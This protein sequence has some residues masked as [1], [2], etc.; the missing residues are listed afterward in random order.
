VLCFHSVTDDWEHQLAVRPALFERLLSSL[1]KRRFR[2]LGAAELVHGPRRGLHVTF[3]DAYAD[4]AGALDVL[5]RLRIPATVFASTS[6]ADGGR[7]L[8]VPELAAEAATRPARL[9]TMDWGRLREA[10]VRGFTIGS[11]TVS[12]PH[13]TTLSDGEL[14]RELADSRARI[15]DEVGQPC[16]LFAYPYGEHDARVQAAVRRSGYEAAF[17]L[18][19]GSSRRNWYALPRADV[20]RRDS[21]LRATVKTTFV[22]P[23][24]SALLDR[25]GRRSAS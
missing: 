7:P 9:A 20:Y 14:D 6:F 1:L 16:T 2:P 22:K 19:D 25:L 23:F 3:D 8:D 10:A 18:W 17:A 24:A 4:I 5:E 21:F 12:H 11:H 15:E 13:L